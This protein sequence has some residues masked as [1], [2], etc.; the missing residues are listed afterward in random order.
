MSRCKIPILP[1]PKLA[2]PVSSP[3]FSIPSLPKLPGYPTITGISVLKPKL[4]IPISSPSF[5]LPYFPKL[6]TIGIQVNIPGISISVLIPKL[7]I[8]VPSP[9]FS[10]PSL[11]KL[12]VLPKKPGCPL[13]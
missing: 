9:L 5:S 12:P 6:P 3:S 1:V 10:I 11:P 7:S 13:D 2:I 4:S 8:P